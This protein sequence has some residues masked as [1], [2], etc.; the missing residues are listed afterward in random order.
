MFPTRLLLST[1]LIYTYLILVYTRVMSGDHGFFALGDDAPYRIAVNTALISCSGAL[2]MACFSF[3]FRRLSEYLQRRAPFYMVGLCSVGELCL[4][5]VPPLFTFGVALSILGWGFLTAYILYRAT[6]EVSAT[7]FGRFIGVSYGL[8]AFLQFVVGAADTYFPPLSVTQWVSLPCLAAFAL[9]SRKVN[10]TNGAEASLLPQN[11]APAQHAFFLQSRVYLLLG[12]ALLS[13]LMGFSDCVTVMHFKE[14]APTFPTSRLCYSIGLVFFGWL[15]DKHFSILPAIVLLM[16]AY[17]LWFRALDTQ[18]FLLLSQIV[19]TIFSGPTIILLTVGFL[20]AAAQSDEP[21]RWAAMGRIVGL[22]LTSFGLALGL[23]LWPIISEMTMLAIYTTLL[24]IA[25][26][27]LYHGT[28]IY[29]GTLQTAAT[30]TPIFVVASASA[31]IIEATTP[32]EL[33]TDTSS[34]TKMPVEKP[35]PEQITEDLVPPQTTKE[36]VSA[37]APSPNTSLQTPT[38]PSKVEIAKA[39]SK[40]AFTTYCHRYNLTAKESEILMEILKGQNAEEIAEAQFITKRTVR[41][42]I[43][44][45]LHKTG[46]KTQLAMIA[47]FHQTADADTHQ[48]ND[49]KKSVTM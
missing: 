9:L 24:L 4:Y 3:G 13:L 49:D 5:F 45:L 42:H 31:P 34:T 11:G 39:E 20:H 47:H 37:S 21:E 18:M 44:N 2:G 35:V 25:V 22:P 17:Y 19:E 41:F 29:L 30:E 14:F 23:W 40:D 8:S 15:A 26:V 43:S 1:T 7:L 38:P 32:K 16:N 48:E 46:N 33:P 6:T 27:L 10:Y 28:L 36:F 12:A